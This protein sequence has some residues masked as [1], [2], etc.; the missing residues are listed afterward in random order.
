MP[1]NAALAYAAT[2]LCYQRGM[3]ASGALADAHLTQGAE[4]SAH[5]DR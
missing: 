5:A 2:I 4:T 1:A 3:A